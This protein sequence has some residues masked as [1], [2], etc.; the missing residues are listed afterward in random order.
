MTEDEALRAWR[1]GIP[2]VLKTPTVDRVRYERILSISGRTAT[3]KDKC[4]HSETHSD[5]KNLMT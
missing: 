3:L 4:G 2:V 5:I 1:L